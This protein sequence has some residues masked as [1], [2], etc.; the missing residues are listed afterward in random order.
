M[1]ASRHFYET[2]RRFSFPTCCDSSSS[3]GSVIDGLPK[4]VC[5]CYCPLE[6]AAMT[7]NKPSNL[8]MRSW[9]RIDVD[10]HAGHTHTHLM[11]VCSS[12]WFQLQA[13]WFSSHLIY[14]Y[15]S[16]LTSH[17][18]EGEDSRRQHDPHVLAAVLIGDQLHVLCGKAFGTVKDA[19]MTLICKHTQL[20]LI[21]HPS[22]CYIKCWAPPGVRAELV[23]ILARLHD[24]VTGGNQLKGWYL[25]NCVHVKVFSECFRYVLLLYIQQLVPYRTFLCCVYGFLIAKFWIPSELCECTLDS[26]VSG[27]VNNSC[28]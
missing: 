26:N 22:L 9:R 16:S 19:S 28:E 20:K 4:C 3:I 21:K 18:F 17:E 2:H 27:H 5:L 8:L 12:H 15:C 7:W 23:S 11:E 10:T 14:F 24:W 1:F 13:E 25:P 6:L